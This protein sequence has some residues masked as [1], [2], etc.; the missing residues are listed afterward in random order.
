M[1]TRYILL[2]S[3]VISV[4]FATIASIVPFGIYNQGEVSALYPTLIVP[5]TYTFSI[6]SV[7]YLSWFILGLVIFL[8]KINIKREN[9]LLLAA[10][11][12][13]SSLW[14]IP[15]QYLF[16]ATSLIVILWVLYF[17]LILF[18]NSRNESLPFKIVSDTFLWWIIVASLANLHLVLYSYGIYFYPLELTFIS[19]IWWLI[20]NAYLLVRYNSFAPSL[21][22]IWALV[23]IIIWQ[24]AYSTVTVSIFSIFFIAWLLSYLGYSYALAKK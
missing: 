12:I 14:L 17:L 24:D 6:W 2:V 9:I 5:A 19:I 15:S 1:H 18:F 13:L 21:V 11:Q 23:W 16:T 22:L 7:I 4:L 8:W 10:A 3:T 20:L